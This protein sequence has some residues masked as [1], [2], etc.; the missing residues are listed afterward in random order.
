MNKIFQLCIIL[1]IT[2]SCSK[3]ESYGDIDL[4][5]SF[6]LINISDI[7]TKSSRFD[8]DTIKISGKLYLEF[9]N[10]GIFNESLSIWI[11]NLKPAISD[12]IKFG[13]RMHKEL[14][15]KYVTLIGIYKSGKTGHL[16]RYDGEF[17]K[18]L[19]LRTE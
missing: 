5:K 4:D 11:N 17:K 19:Y 10:V 8:N 3:P 18:I 2:V 1:I 15:G 6:E 12:D 14:N 13:D 9:E 16:N 7:K